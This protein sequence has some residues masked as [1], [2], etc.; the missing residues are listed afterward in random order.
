MILPPGSTAT[1]RVR[2]DTS[3]PDGTG[4]I[5]LL[6]G[7]G[8]PVGQPRAASVAIMDALDPVAV[9]LSV[10]D[11]VQAVRDGRTE[12]VRWVSEDD[13]TRW[14]PSTNRDP[15]RSSRGWTVVGSASIT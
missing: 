14:S 4:T 12:V 10:G 15:E 1:I 9:A 5:T 3:N 13:A 7:E 2:V 6:D 8:N 11:V